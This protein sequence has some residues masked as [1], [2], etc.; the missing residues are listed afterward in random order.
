MPEIWQAGIAHMARIKSTL[1]IG[2]AAMGMALLAACDPATQVK[3]IVRDDNNHPLQQ[4]T[5]I[6]ESDANISGGAALKKEST[7][8]T[9]ADGV[10]NFVTITAPAG[11]VRVLIEQE[12][13][14]AWQKDIEPNS[15]TDLGVIV[16]ESE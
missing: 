14:K 7:Q 5:V 9:G 4:V 13:F 1:L 10:F 2:L 12:G 3:G 16:L 11:R 15:T 6:L 8:K